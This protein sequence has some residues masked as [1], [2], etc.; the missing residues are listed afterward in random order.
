MEDTMDTIESLRRE[1]EGTKKENEDL[2]RQ[3]DEARLNWEKCAN[4]WKEAYARS[5][6]L[7]KELELTKDRW[8]E[9]A[10]NWEASVNANGDKDEEILKIIDAHE[11]DV[12]QMKE[13]IERM[14]NQIDQ[15]EATI[16]PIMERD[17]QLQEE[18]NKL[19]K[20]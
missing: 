4:G 11:E 8:Q 2:Q 1:L 13:K 14:Y 10:K 7:E 15:L 20:G 3:L 6:E 16:K 18:N 12:Q 17:I 9:C 5:Q 19:R